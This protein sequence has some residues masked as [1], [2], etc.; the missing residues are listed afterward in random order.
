MRRQ[1]QPVDG[2]TGPQ[3]CEVNGYPDQIHE[4]EFQADLDRQVLR[5]EGEARH[6]CGVDDI[7]LGIDRLQ[8]QAAPHAGRALGMDETDPRTGERDLCGEV[9]QIGDGGRK[10][11][12]PEP[13]N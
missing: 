2:N 8:R 6:Q 11:Q 1:I 3:P 10:Q 12:H 5:H 7:G 9:E 13:G 4:E